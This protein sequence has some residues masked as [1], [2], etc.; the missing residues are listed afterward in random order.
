MGHTRH[1]M[2]PFPGKALKILLR[3]F[4]SHTTVLGPKVMEIGDVVCVL[5]GGKRSSDHKAVGWEV[6]VCQGVVCLGSQEG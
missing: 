2:L 6:S 5:L 4:H 1:A 3:E